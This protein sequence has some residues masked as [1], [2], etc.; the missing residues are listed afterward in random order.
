[1][2]FG[3]L[4]VFYVELWSSRRISNRNLFLTTGVDYSNSV[5]HDQV[6][7]LWDSKYSLLF[8]PVAG[9]EP[10]D[11]FNQK[12]TP[13]RHVSLQTIQSEFLGLIN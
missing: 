2:S 8:L 1:M 12:H 4:Q 3:L 7:A 9:I 10:A 13:L 6:Q 11:D 5:N